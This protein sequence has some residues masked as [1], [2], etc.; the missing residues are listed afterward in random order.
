MSAV[1]TEGL[2]LVPGVF[3]GTSE[4]GELRVLLGLRSHSLGEA[5]P[6]KHDLLRSLARGRLQTAHPPAGE[7]A[8][9]LEGLRSGGWLSRV[10]A[11]GERPLYT[12]RPLLPPRPDP[13]VAPRGLVLSRFAVVHREADELVIE[14]PLA[15]AQVHLHDP[16]L[17]EVLGWLAD[18]GR[19]AVPGT[20][21]GLLYHDLYWARL[22]VPA[23]GPEERELRLR[24]WSPHELWFHRRTRISDRADLSSGYG[25]TLWAEGRFEQPPTR[26]EPYPGPAVQLF[27]PDLDELRR[28]DPPLAAVMEDRRSDRV[29]DDSRP[30]TVGQLGELLYRSARVRTVTDAQGRAHLSRPYPAGGSVFELEIYP[31]VR[32][33]DGLDPG[34]YHYDSHEHRLVLVR[35]P[36]PEMGKLLATAR[37]GTFERRTP[38][39]LLVVTARFGR[40]MWTYEQ[41]P[42]SLILKHVGVLY[43]TLYLA[44]SAMGLA[45]CGLG[46]GDADAINQASGRDYTVESAVGEFL[47]GSRPEGGHA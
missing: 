46:G 12:V 35:G 42:Y 24:Q 15:W 1:L 5:D 31:V 16:A 47:V 10:V 41:M 40:L 43:Q 32:L 25:R 6:W 36:G 29:H 45:A 23:E 20:E 13:G 3:S 17:L 8:D 2:S 39:V 37:R 4:D 28:A 44:A 38:Q 11:R 9:L 14:S 26:P 21:L 7:V 18:P 34:I 19:L 33:V 30:I 22:A 27:R